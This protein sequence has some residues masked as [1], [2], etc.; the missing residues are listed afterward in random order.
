M[1]YP[2]ETALST[3]TG[4]LLCRADDYRDMINTI[5]GTHIPLWNLHTATQHVAA[6]I[7]THYPTITGITPPE[8]T[9]PTTTQRWLKT[10]TTRL[11]TKLLDIPP[12]KTPPPTTTL[13]QH[14]NTLTRRKPPPR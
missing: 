7:T 9:D 13:T 14:L 2:T 12:M 1:K 5:T 3:L 8:N 11:G 10:L 6:H 4:R